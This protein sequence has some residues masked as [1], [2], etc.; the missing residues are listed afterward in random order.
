MDPM[1]HLRSWP[2][3][4]AAAG[5]LGGLV[6]P[7]A[8]QAQVMASDAAAAAVDP[9]AGALTFSWSP[10]SLHYSPSEEHKP[11]VAAGFRWALGGP[12]FGGGAF[13]TN[14]F[15]QPSAYAFYGQR[16]NGGVPAQPRFYVEWSLGLMYGYVRDRADEVPLNVRGFS[17]V[18]LLSPGWQLTPRS[19]VQ[20]NLAGTA[21]IMLQFNHRID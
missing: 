6:L 2:G 15:G 10:Y 17:P 19:S 4:L 16:Y 7:G 8:G 18:F 11:S 12:G 5:L 21:A 13:F 9:P 3:A 20:L 14:S 1:R